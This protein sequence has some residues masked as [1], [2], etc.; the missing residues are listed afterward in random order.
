MT[1]FFEPI[2][3]SATHVYHSALELS[4]LSSIV[5]K[6][7]Y[8]RRPIPFPRV[9]AGTPDSWDPSAAISHTH[10]AYTSSV[11]WSQCGQFVAV[12]T[13]EAVEIR[14]ALTSGLLSTLQPT[15]PTSELAGEPTYSPDG[16]SIACVSVAIIIIW[17]IQTGGV[18]KEIQCDEAGDASLVWSL[19]GWAIGTMFRDRDTWAMRVYDVTSGTAL[20]YIKLQSRDRPHLWVHG[21]YFRVA[22]TGIEDGALAIHIFEVWSAITKIES[23]RTKSLGPDGKIRS[24]SPTTYR[25]SVWSDERFLV[26]DIRSSE[27]LL[28]KDWQAKSD[29]FSSDGSFFAASP[30]VGDRIHIWKYTAG[31]YTPWKE[32][33]TQGQFNNDLQFSPTS[34]SILVRSGQVLRVWPL[35]IPSTS[36]ST[37]D[38]QLVAFSCSGA[39]IAAAND[40]TKIVII[41]NL[42][43]PAASQ[44]IHTGREIGRLALTGN[45]LLVVG[46]ESTMAWLLTGEGTVDR[47]PGDR[48][49]GPGDSIWTVPIGSGSKLTS[50]FT[51]PDFLVEGEIG[52]IRDRFGSGTVKHVYHTRTGKIIDSSPLPSHRATRWRESTCDSG[53]LHLRRRDLDKRSGHA[54]DNWLVSKSTVERG[55]VKDP[56]GKHRL[57]V[58]VEWRAFRSASW[59]YDITTLQLRLISHQI[60]I[61]F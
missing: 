2:N 21:K 45:I 1:R 43:S 56:A 39:Y 26:L 35:D 50:S 25:I 11:T 47:V 40:E 61:K 5:R 9:V 19:G 12:R 16:R 59:Y 36:L 7:H 13:K 49:A 52:A 60:I 29:C 17:D 51:R 57:W 22:V 41:T 54:E 46:I 55:W 23:F 14:D 58:P 4:P 34:S 3:A 44:L 27:C 53:W 38:R 32:F 42:L 28:S 31:H 24:F 33:Q 10:Y 20:S 37:Y 8:R 48:R 18:M 30:Y 15:E 6:L